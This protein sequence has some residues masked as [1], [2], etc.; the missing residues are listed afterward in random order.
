MTKKVKI[1]VKTN[2]LYDKGWESNR[3]YIYENN[4]CVYWWHDPQQDSTLLYDFT[5]NVG[6]EWTITVGN[7]SVTLHVE[8][9]GIVEYNER[10]FRSMTV[11]DDKD[12]FSGTIV[13]SVGHVNSFFPEQLLENKN[14]YKVDGIRCFWDEG[15][16]IYHEGDDDCDA[17]YEQIHETEED[18]D[19]S[20]NE[21]TVYPNPTNGL[22]N[23]T[24][25]FETFQETSLREAEYHII[26]I[27]GETVM[28]GKIVYENKT[29][30]VS[31][32]PCGVY[33]MEINDKTMKIVIK[34]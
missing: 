6:D 29:I 16:I 18:D 2:T 12:I 4:G 19:I 21:M 23:V 13:C 11:S 32:L 27:M 28:S 1:I 15:T 3:E 22:I 20:E 25:E 9:I 14:G 33:L 17:I 34:K 24:I 5:A 26:N 10:V 7:D 31:N 30:D 8:E